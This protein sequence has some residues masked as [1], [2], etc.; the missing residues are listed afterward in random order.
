MERIRTEAYIHIG[1]RLVS[2][3]A[4]SGSQR[5]QLAAWL[6]T[7]YLNALFQGQA[8]FVPEESLPSNGT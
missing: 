8:I 3:S 4:L 2:T 1:S 7:T 5:E 6:K